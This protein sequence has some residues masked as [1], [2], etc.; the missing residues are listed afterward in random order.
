MNMISNIDI[1]RET[2]AEAADH[3]IMVDGKEVAGK[4]LIIDLIG[5]KHLDDDA[6]IRTAMA[7]CV[8]AC[9]ATL[10]HLH[11][12]VFTPNGGV[13]GVAVLAE[14]HI[15]THT[16]PERNY[17]AFDVF[18]CG[19]AQPHKAVAILKEAFEAEEAQVK[20]ILRGE[21]A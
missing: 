17:A 4:H 16:W 13:S 1:P 11:T 8:K 5:A 7:D 9:G 18:M 3:F 20:T 14:S 6:R 21:G 10:L 12:H 15:S 2:E 19:D